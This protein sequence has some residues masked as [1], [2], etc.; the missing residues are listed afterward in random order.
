M[1]VDRV[2]ITPAAT[3]LVRSLRVKHGP[4][5]FHQSGG[6]CDGGALMCFRKDEFGL[7]RVDVLIGEIEGCPVYMRREQLD[8]WRYTQLI[9][10][11]VPGRGSSFSLEAPE[12]MRFLTRARIFDSAELA[13]SEQLEEAAV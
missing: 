4:L 6:C 12:G 5:V 13:E 8:Y 9:I 2:A 7:G 10:D 11:V 1:S 3:A